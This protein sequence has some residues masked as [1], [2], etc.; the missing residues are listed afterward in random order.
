MAT[1]AIV[2]YDGTD[3][4]ADAVAF[5][6]LLRRAGV[7]LALAY[8]RHAADP[9]QQR[10]VVEREKASRL[11]DAGAALLGPPDADRHV[12]LSASTPE[13]LGMLAT[14]LGAN[15]IVFGSEYRTPEGTVQPGT[16]AQRLL[17]AG[18]TSVGVAPAGM[19]GWS[20]AT[21]SAIDAVASDGADEAA[22]S[23]AAAL[24]GSVVDAGAAELLVL[25][26]ATRSRL[27]DARHP[28]IVVAGAGLSF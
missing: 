22:A 18:T 3:N 9:D 8:V 20:D 23:L 16:S 11:L 28:V 25:A 2:S 19:R 21:I 17:D 1:R 13:G 15:L 10:E 7:D 14:D 5:G 4:D 24:G 27:D 26:T 12:V 6:R